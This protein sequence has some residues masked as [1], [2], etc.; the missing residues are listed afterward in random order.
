M[1]KS[2]ALKSGYEMPALGLGTWQLTGQNC[3]DIVRQAI[4]MGYRH[5]DTAEL[6]EN[7]AEVGQALKGVERSELF[8][9]SKVGTKHFSRNDLIKACEGSLDKL[10]TDYLDMYLLHWPNDDV[11]IAETL[12]AVN[13]LSKK[14]MIRSFG[15]SN[16]DVSRMEEVISVSAVPISNLQIEY[17]PFTD[18]QELPKYCRQERI[19]ITAYSP[20]ARGKVFKDQTLVQIADKHGKT[21]AQVSLRWLLQKGHVVIPKSSSKEHLQQNMEI[22]DWQLDEDDIDAIDGIEKDQ[23]LIDTK[24]T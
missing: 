23:R 24:Y 1:K 3:I 4:E 14:D 9:T 15:L 7:E 8:I 11:D 12:E 18:R 2:Y 22:F 17:H 19:I 21:A 6:Y 13:E 5:I 20:L 10:G 16:F